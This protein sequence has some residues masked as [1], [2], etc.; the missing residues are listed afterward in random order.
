LSKIV[1]FNVETSQNIVDRFLHK[2]F[3]SIDTLES[4]SLHSKCILMPQF[5]NSI[6]PSIEPH[7][8][9]IDICCNGPKVN[10]LVIQSPLVS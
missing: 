8:Q 2:F 1:F 3:T 7:A 6:C 10:A 9:V 5:I 4:Q